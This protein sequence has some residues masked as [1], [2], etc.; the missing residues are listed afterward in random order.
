MSDEGSLPNLQVVILLFPH[1]TE[2]KVRA[3]ALV[4]H[5]Y[6]LAPRCG[7]WDLSSLTRD[8]TLIPCIGSMEYQSLDLQGSS[9]GATL[10]TGSIFMFTHF[11]F[12][13]SAITGQRPLEAD[14]EAELGGSMVFGGHLWKVWAEGGDEW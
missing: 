11:V 6:F 5:L 3:Q 9:S 2:G 13:L 1:V 12:L 14:A 4:C 8:Q 7:M 10:D